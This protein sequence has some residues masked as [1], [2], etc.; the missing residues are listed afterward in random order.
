[1]QQDP[2]Y[3]AENSPINLLDS[4]YPSTFVVIAT[5]DW[6]IPPAESRSVVEKLKSC[7]VEATFAEAQ[8]MG[9]GVC[10]DA[11]SSWPEDQKWWEEAILPSLEWTE[12]KLRS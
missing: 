1:M 4:Y 5:A 11:R 6:L 2:P 10:E 9:H 8:G 3:P 7:G 12:R